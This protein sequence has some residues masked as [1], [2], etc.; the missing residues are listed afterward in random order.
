MKEIPEFNV[1]VSQAINY[2]Y[3]S[4]LAILAFSKPPFI[5]FV[6]IVRITIETIERLSENCNMPEF[7]NHGLKHVCSLIKRTSEWAIADGW[8][9]NINSNEAGYLLMSLLVHDLG[10]LSQEPSDLPEYVALEYKRGTYDL[11]TWVRK[12]HVLRLENL[13]HRIFIDFEKDN[14]ELNKHIDLIAR[15][16]A[17]HNYWPWEKQ[18]EIS[19]ELTNF[20]GIPNEKIRA[21]NAVI[22]VADLLDEDSERCDSETLIKHK[23]GNNINIAHWYRHALTKKVCPIKDHIVE[24]NLRSLEGM[25]NT[26]EDVFKVIRNQFKV[27]LIYN[28]YL[29]KIDATIKKI[30]FSSE[31]GMPEIDKETI[32]LDVWRDRVELKYSMKELLMST[33]IP[34]ARGEIQNQKLYNKLKEFIIE[35]VYPLKNNELLDGDK[36]LFDDEKLLYKI[37]CMKLDNYDEILNYYKERIEHEFLS[38]NMGRVKNLCCMLLEYL[39]INNTNKTYWII[40]YLI[41]LLD[42]EQ[43]Y[44]L[45][46]DHIN[47]NGI[48]SDII[49]LVIASLNLDEGEFEKYYYKVINDDLCSLKNDF[50]TRLLFSLLIEYSYM[51]NN[52]II[53]N[54]NLL[55]SKLNTNKFL[56]EYL[57]TVIERLEIQFALIHGEEP[58]VSIDEFKG[59]KE[60]K[61]LASI[62]HDFFTSDVKQLDSS[63][64]NFSKSTTEESKYYKSYMSLVV[65][66]ENVR[67][68]S[69]DTLTENESITDE[70]KSNDI[71]ENT[72]KEDNYTKHYRYLRLEFENQ[73]NVLQTRRERKIE[74]LLNGDY[75]NYKS[76]E[77]ILITG[78]LESMREWDILGVIAFKTLYAQYY[79]KLGQ[80]YYNKEKQG[81]AICKSI[82]CLIQ[83]LKCYDE[84][85]YND[86]FIGILEVNEKESIR[87]LYKFIFN[88]LAKVYW[89]NASTWLKALGDLLPYNLLDDW[90][91]W[92]VNYNK[93]TRDHMI[94]IRLAELDFINPI[95]QEYEFNNRQMDVLQP[96]LFNICKKDYYWSIETDLCRNI[97]KVLPE[98]SCK[99]V[100][101][102][103]TK[104]MEEN[105]Q[106]A[107]IYINTLMKL[108]RERTEIS[109][110]IKKMISERYELTKNKDYLKYKQFIG[111]KTIK[112]LD[113]PNIDQISNE[114]RL[115]LNQYADD[116]REGHHHFNNLSNVEE[117]LNNSNWAECETSSVNNIV[118]IIKE[119]VEKTRNKLYE[120]DYYYIYSILV[121]FSRGASDE[122]RKNILDLSFFIYGSF[123]NSDQYL[124][125]QKNN[126]HFAQIK[127]GKAIGFL[128]LICVLIEFCS[129]NQIRNVIDWCI[130][131][132][133]Y[134]TNEIVIFYP[135]IF[136]YVYIYGSKNLE[137]SAYSGLRVLQIIIKFNNETKKDYLYYILIG[138]EN[139][140]C[141]MK[142]NNDSLFKKII[143]NKAYKEWIS[144][145]IEVAIKSIY[146]EKRKLASKISK[147]FKNDKIF[148]ELL[149][150]LED[151]SRVSIS[152]RISLF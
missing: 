149:K 1:E 93:D 28:D 140:M 17:S 139:F 125:Y 5:N 9:N 55:I 83:S 29:D 44:K 88:K 144:R 128:K 137:D 12:T 38:G 6:N 79:E 82:I 69:I 3:E 72:K 14:E 105:N 142:R 47:K 31:E 76:I 116:I 90:I 101:E 89:D 104:N 11:A 127:D 62:W 119:F 92:V 143:E 58:K 71:K 152:K 103:L 35:K 66:T 22:A 131:I 65:A 102:D 77:I 49:Y 50:E 78:Q 41:Y 27:I 117:L 26:F 25:D 46:S 52:K 51:F 114:V 147:K 53:N 75:N 138:L 136:S 134:V 34:E 74:D 113:I 30:K 10:M 39:N 18:Y 96:I 86:K 110:F 135:Y 94:I 15:M 8:I 81:N 36:L 126:H 23:K 99:Q 87:D 129:D 7:T 115:L 107:G 20:I 40:V 67:N 118:K 124:K 45:I 91:N 24:I 150:R 109:D 112:G 2:I 80:S 148:N 97:I 151:D 100:I 61:V 63:L 64:K 146:S 120:N 68:C 73:M 132:S 37:S 130:E 111:V 145:I 59:E 4:D 85:K 56:Y 13:L 43:D 33:F 57:V 21:L 70:K 133:N 19:D 16:A 121:V 123:E 98:E 60:E 106:Y 108:S 48:Y 141:D 32:G 42:S 54:I 95:I 84:K 122:V